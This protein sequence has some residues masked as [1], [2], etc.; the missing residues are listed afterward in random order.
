MSLRLRQ[1]DQACDSRQRPLI[2]IEGQE[3]R[4]RQFGRSRHLQDVERTMPTLLGARTGK[5]VCLH[6]DGVR[7]RRLELQRARGQVGIEGSEDRTGG[8]TGQSAAKDG[9]ADRVAT[10]ARA[11]GVCASRP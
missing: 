8:R 11:R 6:E 10:S 2:R 7:I 1:R 4:S 3:L 5:P 9:K